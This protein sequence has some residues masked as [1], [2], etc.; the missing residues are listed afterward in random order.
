MK[1]ILAISFAV[2]SISLNAQISFVWAKQLGGTSAEYSNSIAVDAQGNVYTTGQFSGTGTSDFDPGPGVFNLSSSGQSDVF[3]CKQDASGNFVW[4]KKIGAAGNDWA[5]SITIDY[6]GNVLLT[7]GFSTTVDFDPG[8]GV[9]NL[10]SSG[11]FYGWDTFV[12]KLDAN[13]NFVYAKKIGGT[14]DNYGNSISVD[15]LGNVYSVGSFKGTVDFDP[16]IGIFNLT[17]SGSGSSYWVGTYVLK[18]NASGDFLW[19]KTIDTGYDAV[20]SIDSQGNVILTGKYIGIIDFDPGSGVYNLMPSLS[21]SVS[22]RDAFILKLDISGNFVWARLID[23]SSSTVSTSSITADTMNNLYVS[24]SFTELTDFD[25]GVNSFNMTPSLSGVPNAFIIKLDVSGNFTWAKQFQGTE[26]KSNSIVLDAS[27]SVYTTGYFRGTT[28]FNPGSGTFSLAPTS[29]VQYGEA[30]ISKLDAAGDFVWAKKIGGREGRSLAVWAGNI[31]STG[32]LTATADFDPSNVI[33]NLSPLSSQDFYV[34]KMSQCL[35]VIVPVNAGSDQ[36]VCSGAS[37]VLSG[38]GAVSYA[39]SNSVGNGIPFAPS[40]TN[41]YTV[42]GTNINGCSNT[43]QVT[44]TVNPLPSVNAGQDQSV[45]QG[46]MVT[47]AGSGANNYSWNNNVQNNI[48]FTPT[49]SQTYTV[50]GTDNNNCSNTDQVTVTVNP[51]PLV[52][53]GQDQ[54]VCQGDMVTLAG[55]GA[56]NYSWTN[57]VQNNVPFSPQTAQTYTVTGTDNNNCSA[58]DNVIVTVNMNSSGTQTQSALDSYTWPVN[59]QIYSQSGLYTAIIPN[60]QGCDSTITLNLTLSYTGIEELVEDVNIYPNPTNSSITIE[61]QFLLG[62]EILIVDSQGRELFKKKLN[63][64][65]DQFDLSSFADGI[66]YLTM[67]KNTKVFK[68]VKQ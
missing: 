32:D 2:V 1:K 5:N 9:F 45:C 15:N 3:I 36:S 14:E 26:G 21:N 31:Y 27:S 50:T 28:D 63:E 4:A 18:L 23:G 42:T 48:P 62:K 60:A 34:H 37:I 12:M 44:V 30:F 10:S 47:L 56:N 16:G 8:V 20:S 13:G 65:K 7:G 24:G 57:N 6:L 58:T 29:T 64:A 43:D 39:W 22:S 55:S 66:Y 53:A 17:N 61:G 25:P 51:L 46:G 68:I 49:A 54:F 41:T 33:F 11:G 59:G 67:D 38:S 52:N 35:G 40:L 19:A